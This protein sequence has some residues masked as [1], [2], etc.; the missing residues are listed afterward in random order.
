MAKKL[1]FLDLPLGLSS[2]V[3]HKLS[4]LALTDNVSGWDKL[5]GKPHNAEVRAQSSVIYPKK[6]AVSQ[7][8]CH[9]PKR[10]QRIRF[11]A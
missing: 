8:T 5:V 7:K 4:D 2:L 6:L 11:L 3:T 9:A 10:L 1:H